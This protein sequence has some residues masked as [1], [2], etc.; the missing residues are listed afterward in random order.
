MGI[1][2]ILLASS[3]T[4]EGPRR[5]PA[6]LRPPRIV[7]LV[8]PTEVANALFAIQ[9][10][11]SLWGGRFHSLVPCGPNRSLNGFW[12]RMIEHQDP[13]EI[14]DLVGAGIRITTE[15]GTRLS[16]RIQGWNPEKEPL[17]RW[18]ATA[19]SAVLAAQHNDRLEL[20]DF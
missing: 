20:I 7:Y 19:L 18:G 15:H 13:D 10:C 4:L 6:T 16:R 2:D 3:R 8:H 12:Q 14:V 17:W 1:S 5:V 9:S 11:T